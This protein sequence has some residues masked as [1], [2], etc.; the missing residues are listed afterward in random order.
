[1]CVRGGAMITGQWLVV[2]TTACTL[3]DRSYA[4]PLELSV[5]ATTAAAA[6]AGAAPATT[7]DDSGD[8]AAGV[9]VE[10]A[11]GVTSGT[12]I[13]GDPGR[14][15]LVRQ[16]YLHAPPHACVPVCPSVRPSS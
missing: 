13:A 2:Q 12:D 14:A 16:G 6:A 5:Q 8:D 11:A 1:M 7:A 15:H 9:D 10:S 4:H 3:H